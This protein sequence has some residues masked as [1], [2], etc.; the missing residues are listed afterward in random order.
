MLKKSILMFLFSQQVLADSILVAALARIGDRVITTREMQMSAIVGES[1]T[2]F[3]K[4][5]GEKINPFEEV[6]LSQAIFIEAQPFE[7]QLNIGEKK[8][9]II[10]D[11]KKKLSQDSLWQKLGVTEQELVFL[12][13][14]RL[15]VEEF[16]NFKFDPMLIAVSDKEMETY[17]RF[18]L[19]KYGNRSYEDL[20]D[21]IR[22]VIRKQKRLDVINE[23]I[24]IVKKRGSIYY[25]SDVKTS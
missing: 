11:I 8:I 7:K 5:M 23:W 15:V 22:E 25:F 3:E 4:L 20:R 10:N 14:R 1:F 2:S 24:G 12:A 6:I 16:L 21:K 18:N 9:K 19:E 17:Y 13:E